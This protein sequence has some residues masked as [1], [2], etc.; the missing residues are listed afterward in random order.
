MLP[1]RCAVLAPNPMA[2]IVPT[3]LS[4]LHQVKDL[5]VE[6]VTRFSSEP[7]CW[8]GVDAVIV[9]SDRSSLTPGLEQ[10]ARVLSAN[11]SCSIV[12][13][14]DALDEGEMLS[15]LAA[16]AFD[17]VAAPFAIGELQAR[18]RRALGLT[19]ATE[20][21]RDRGF[22]DLRLRDL[23]GTSSAF[24]RQTAKL[25]LL[26]GH[27]VGVLL[28]GETG[29][30]KEVF[31]QAIHYLSARA[32]RPW[33][34]VNC[35]AIPTELIESEL[36]GHVRGAYTTAH[37]ARKGLVSEA[38]GGTLLLDEIDCLSYGA[39]AKLLRFLQEKEF[40]PVG[41][42]AICRADVR[43][44]AT[45]NSRLGALVAKGNFRRDLYF[46]L[47]VLSVTLP[48]LRDRQEDVPV[49]ALHFIQRFGRAFNRRVTGLTP[50]ALR[51]LMAY[52]WP[53]NVRELKHV[54]E[55]AVLLSNGPMLGSGDLELTDEGSEPMADES[56]RA[57]KARVVQSFERAYIE[58]MLST[59]AGNVSHAARMAKKNRR[60][61]WEL[62]RK[63]RIDPQ[64]FR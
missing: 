53:G 34:A 61:F 49:L 6:S 31:A 59:C 63:H 28:L 5:V 50:L 37:T 13:V 7:S 16:G 29:T 45:S 15:L 38:E 33:V 41:S 39:Q 1:L 11:P 19:P 56:F 17:F 64:P 25:P 58:Q 27:D 22:T 36:F 12:A 46:R 40:R 30:G 9:V 42:N 51:R 2:W 55:R 35:A 57:A 62:L 10:I 26:A 43:V 14:G 20:S 18:I 60:A 24:L 44:I 32:S 47:N 48:P 54:I 52:T 4:T 8:T 21:E 23:I 3:V